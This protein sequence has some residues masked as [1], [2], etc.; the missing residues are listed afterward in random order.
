MSRDTKGRP[1]FSFRPNLER[2]D[3]KRA[4]EILQAVPEGRKNA[5]L[6]EAILSEQARGDLEST[7]R[8]I[9]KEELRGASLPPV[10]EPSPEPE[11]P[12]RMLGFLQALTDE[13]EET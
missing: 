8:R 1:R 7:L 13:T 12:D 11:I 4:W 6:V 9:L 10:Q 2:P 3:H 5:F